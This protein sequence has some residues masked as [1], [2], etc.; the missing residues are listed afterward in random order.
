MTAISGDIDSETV[1]LTELLKACTK[2]FLEN[3]RVID[4]MLCVWTKTDSKVQN[5]VMRRIVEV[6]E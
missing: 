1:N 5:F 4:N 6:L 2:M 3:E